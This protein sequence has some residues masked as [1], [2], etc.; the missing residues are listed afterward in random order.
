LAF[1]LR[2]S[3]SYFPAESNGLCMSEIREQ[4]KIDLRGA[5]KARA[6]EDVAT[7]RSVLAAID[8]AEAVPVAPTSSS[9][10]PVIGKSA[11]VPR[12]LLS[13]ADIRQIVQDEVDE[14]RHAS[15]TYRQIG[16]R[17]EAERL[18]RAADLLAAYLG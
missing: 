15:E 13:A 18:Q 6:T 3:V 11:D 1:E 17:A 10:E 5:M 4:L 9:V 16:E 7:L 2:L 8:N 12:K 14:R